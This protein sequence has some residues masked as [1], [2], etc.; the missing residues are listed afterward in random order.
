MSGKKTALEDANGLF[1]HALENLDLGLMDRVWSREAWVRCVH[2]GW[3]A[4]V[5]WDAIRKSW[6]QIFTNTRWMRVTPTAVG[7]VD[8]G[9]VGLVFCSENITATQGGDVGGTS[10]QATNI[11]RKEAGLW[12]LV[13][14]HASVA[15]LRVTQPFSGTFQ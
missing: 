1:Y 5:G 2:P 10:A 15:P 6:E 11:F 14:H 8:F 12:K 7:A 13:L 9:D 4:L 3:D